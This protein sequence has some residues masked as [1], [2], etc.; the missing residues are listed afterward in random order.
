MGNRHH[1]TV[2]T[3]YRPNPAAAAAAAAKLKQVRMESYTQQKELLQSQLDDKTIE[4]D[5]VHQRLLAIQSQIVTEE[6]SIQDFQ[7]EYND[8]TAK[9]IV[10]VGNTG[11]GKSTVGNRLCGDESQ[12]A[13]SGPFPTSNR[14]DSCTLQL[15]KQRT[16]IGSVKIT[17]VDAPGWGDTGGRD[18]TH[19]NNL[20]AYLYGCGGINHF[21]LVRNAANYRFDDHFRMM[22]QRYEHMFGKIFW[23][24]LMVVLTRVE[25]GFAERQFNETGQDQEIRNRIYETFELE[26]E[27]C[28]IP[29][30]PIGF[31]NYTDAIQTIV[32]AL[33]DD[34]FECDEI[35]SP[36][37]QLKVKE[38]EI[39]KKDQ[40]MN[41]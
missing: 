9:I 36:L 15:S 17:V 13:D 26:P 1:H 18:R 10:L 4:Y 6:E 11:D 8:P 35:K 40:D 33:S 28:A 25:Q 38:A 24:H 14:L 32:G 5:T 12:R 2:H 29:V 19:A 37:Q 3:V 21:V 16:E 22:L 31:D 34:K 23:K 7:D 39:M 20:C 30:I 41:R 27:E